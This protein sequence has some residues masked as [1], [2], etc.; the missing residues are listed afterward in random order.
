MSEVLT[1]P[2]NALQR[3]LWLAVLRGCS[4]RGTVRKYKATSRRE[5]ESEGYR[6]SVEAENEIPPGPA[7][8]L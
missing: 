7:L 8:I 2:E 5:G 1:H 6:G 4:E 3:P